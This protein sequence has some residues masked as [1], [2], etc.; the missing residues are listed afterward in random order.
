MK[1]VCN[2]VVFG[3]NRT[4]IWLGPLLT[5]FNKKEVHNPVLILLASNFNIY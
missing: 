5:D 1:N 4:V 2:L 3:L